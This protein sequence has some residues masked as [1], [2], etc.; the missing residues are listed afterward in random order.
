M[1]VLKIARHE[2]FAQERLEGKTKGA[3]CWTPSGHRIKFSIA[4]TAQRQEATFT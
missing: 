4:T 2:R 3:H 1:P